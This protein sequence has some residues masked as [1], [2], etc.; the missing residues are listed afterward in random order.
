MNQDLFINT[1]KLYY[2]LV[3]V[4]YKDGAVCHIPAP[5][6]LK[7]INGLSFV[8]TLQESRKARDRNFFKCPVCGTPSFYS[9]V[10]EDCQGLETKE[11]R[12]YKSRMSRRKKIL[13]RRVLEGE[14]IPQSVVRV[15]FVPASDDAI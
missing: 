9:G 15:E 7:N 4:E 2:S 11:Y 5:M 1:I 6:F 8:T 12:K 10:C 13:L 3:E 14:P